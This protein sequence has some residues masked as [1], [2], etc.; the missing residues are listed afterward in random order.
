MLVPPAQ[1]YETGLGTSIKPANLALSG[2]S[3]ERIHIDGNMVRDPESL[4]R[5]L[6][7]VALT[8]HATATVA[9]SHPTA[10]S[11]LIR[12]ILS[13]N[14][15]LLVNHMLGRAFLGW[16]PV[17]MRGGFVQIYELSPQPSSVDP[18][19]QISLA[20]NGSGVTFDLLVY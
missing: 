20:C 8:L 5:V 13:V 2:G 4:T 1:Q 14:G 3:V 17:R 12:N 6:Q 7:K 16:F 19:K 11:M 9:A 18:K 10:S 15:G